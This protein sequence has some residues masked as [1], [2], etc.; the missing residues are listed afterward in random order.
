M[1]SLEGA[2][3]VFDCLLGTDSTLRDLLV[4]LHKLSQDI[5]KRAFSL[6][7]RINLVCFL[8]GGEKWGSA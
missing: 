3:Y 6:I 2:L 1:G 8:S 5:I 7:H 4:V